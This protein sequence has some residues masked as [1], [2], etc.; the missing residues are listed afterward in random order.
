MVVV[1]GLNEY[2]F[3]DLSQDKELWDPW[4]EPL[5]L[6]EFPLHHVVKEIP[7]LSDSFVFCFSWSDTV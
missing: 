5:L 2:L 3:A 4:G 1:V 6:L 7:L